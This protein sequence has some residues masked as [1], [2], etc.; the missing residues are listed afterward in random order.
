MTVTHHRHPGHVD[1]PWTWRGQSLSV[2]RRVVLRDL[3][4]ALGLPAGPDEPAGVLVLRVAE[5]LRGLE[6]PPGPLE[7]WLEG[8]GAPPEAAHARAKPPT[9][10]RPQLPSEER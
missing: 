2:T 6:L 1:A 9:F 4:R 5:R 10:I 7:A 3:C 8:T